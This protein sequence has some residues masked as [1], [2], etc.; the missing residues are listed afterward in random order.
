MKTR[1]AIALISASML[2]AS[3]GAVAT[4]TPAHAQGPFPHPMIRPHERHPE[5]RRAMRQLQNAKASLQSAAHDY[6][7]HRDQAIALI[8][9]AISQ[10][11]QAMASD[12]D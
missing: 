10:I 11:Q 12:R 8:D 2:L 9:Q 6:H 3:I 5:L 1:K 4:Q 7:G